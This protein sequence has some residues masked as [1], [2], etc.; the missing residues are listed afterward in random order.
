MSE[1]WNTIFDNVEPHKAL[2]SVMNLNHHVCQ[3]CY[4]IT[5]LIKLYKY[6]IKLWLSFIRIA[7]PCNVVTSITSKTK[8]MM[9]CRTGKC[10]LAVQ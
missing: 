10:A 8:R 7:F 9:G 6:F 5:D 3:V 1:F 2:R 4:V